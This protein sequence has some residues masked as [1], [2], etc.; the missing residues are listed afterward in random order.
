MNYSSFFIVKISLLLLF[1][2]TFQNSF[3][4]L[5]P[6]NEN[7]YEI[8]RTRFFEQFITT[9]EFSETQQG[10]HIP[11]ARRSDNSPNA[12][13]VFSDAGIQLS[14]Y[15]AFLAT[16]LKRLE[17]TNQ[18][19]DET[20]ELLEK[21]LQTI[22]RLDENAEKYWSANQSDEFCNLN[23][24]FIRDDVESDAKNPT[25]FLNNPE[26]SMIYHADF[27]VSSIKSDFRVADDHGKPAEMSQDQVWHLFLGL[28]LVVKLI[29]EKY[30]CENS[31]AEILP[32]KQIAL[33][34]VERIIIHMQGN[35]TYPWTIINPQ[36]NKK[37]RR[38]ANINEVFG[39]IKRDYGFAEA[40]AKIFEFAKEKRNFHRWNSE[41]HKTDFLYAARYFLKTPNLRHKHYS[42]NALMTIIGEQTPQE[43][44]DNKNFFQWLIYS[45]QVSNYHEHF[46]L[47]YGLLH[48]NYEDL[49]PSAFKQKIEKLLN[50]APEN[51]PFNFSYAAINGA[52]TTFFDNWEQ[53]DWSC[54]NRLIWPEDLGRNVR[55]TTG[56]YNGLDYLLLYNL[57]QLVFVIEQNT[58]ISQIENPDFLEAYFSK[59]KLILIPRKENRI[60]VEIYDLQGR[61]VYKQILDIFATHTID[62]KNMKPAVYFAKIYKHDRVV[63]LKFVKESTLRR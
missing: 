38:G 21:A 58:S 28:S 51:P 37:V 60:I 55:H 35:E 12:Q 61:V 15:I 27:T 63:R 29:D 17:L 59:D 39:M 16:E 56:F 33:D 41:N 32:V 62:L 49:K 8:Y 44:L 47:I 30:T 26:N 24:F 45:N 36:T 25:C 40:A 3:S 31:H 48:E 53:Q 2:F 4:Q 7:K 54:V 43:P 9:A 10:L 13:L 6:E 34:I 1:F 14:L 42:F 20:L 18:A 50:S 52:D 23:G 22:D 19:I 11:A 46:P 5:L 57:Y